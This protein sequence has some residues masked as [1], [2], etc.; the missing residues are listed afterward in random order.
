MTAHYALR[1]IA[2]WDGKSQGIVQVLAGA[3]EAGDYLDC[4]KNLRAL[5]INPLSYIN[6]L[7]EVS[8]YLIGWRCAD[9]K[10]VP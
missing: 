5:N 6:K 1:G 8:S 10:G 2:N 7:D 4:V 3:F 9:S